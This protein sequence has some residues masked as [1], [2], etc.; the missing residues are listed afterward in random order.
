VGSRGSW[1]STDLKSVPSPTSKVEPAAAAGWRFTITDNGIGI[2]PA[3]RERIFAMFK[4]L[5]SREDYPG[6]GIGL[7]LVKKIVERHGQ[8]CQR[9][10]QPLRNRQPVLVHASG[11]GGPMTTAGSSGGVLSASGGRPVDI[12][13]VEDS[14]SD[15]A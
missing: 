8:A 5:H 11:R 15:V 10:G 9:R 3:H 14:P 13:L 4:R 7:A 2:D 6:T 1:T 12:L